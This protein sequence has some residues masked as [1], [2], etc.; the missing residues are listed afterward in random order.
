MERYQWFERHFT[1]GLS[2]KMLPFYL[3]RLEGAIARVER[4]VLGIP[5]KILRHKPEG[6]WS[7]KEIIGHLTEVDEIALERVDEIVY[8]TSPISCAVFK[9]KHD[10]NAMPMDKLLSRFSESRKKC[11]DRFRHVANDEMSRTSL[12][13]RLKVK[14][15]PVDLAWFNAEH[16]DHHLVRISEIIYTLSQKE[17]VHTKAL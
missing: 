14:M 5:D 6:T 7:I 10:Y 8:G 17:N 12:H 15:T 2:S 1:F 13:P 4:K 9:I 11:I 3:E 16:D